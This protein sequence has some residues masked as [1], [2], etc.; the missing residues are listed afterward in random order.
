M[1]AV[2]QRVKHASVVVEG[3]TISSIEGGLLTLLGVAKG[4]DETK[5]AKMIDK[6]CNLR[7]FEDDQGKMNHS[8][9]DTGGSHLIVSQFTLLGDCSK[10]TRPG[11]SDAEAPE[12]AKDLYEKGLALSQAAGIPT[13]G[14]Q[15]RAHMEV[16]LLNDGPVTLLLEF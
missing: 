4:D 3:K 11:F 15:F 5:L 13:F 14:G 1:K 16:S 12:R 6:I 2:I 9:K 10:G 8:L 7:I